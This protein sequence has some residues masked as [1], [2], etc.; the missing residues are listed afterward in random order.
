MILTASHDCGARQSSPSLPTLQVCTSPPMPYSQH[1]AHSFVS[2]TYRTTRQ[3]IRGGTGCNPAVRLHKCLGLHHLDWSRVTHCSRSN[4][5]TPKQGIKAR[6]SLRKTRSSCIN[7][8]YNIHGWP[9]HAIETLPS[10]TYSINFLATLQRTR[11]TKEEVPR[12]LQCPPCIYKSLSARQSM[13]Q[14]GKSQLFW[15]DQR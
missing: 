7:D 13:F 14:V 10:W 5:T 15:S 1:R 8:R 12:A 4:Q 11:P 6:P 2:Y 9:E 3:D